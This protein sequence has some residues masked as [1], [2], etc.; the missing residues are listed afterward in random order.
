MSAA[1]FSLNQPAAF[2]TMFHGAPSTAKAPVP[3]KPST[4]LSAVPNIAGSAFLPPTA[5]GMK[6]RGFFQPYRPTTNVTGAAQSAAK[7]RLKALMDSDDDD[8]ELSILGAFNGS[9]GTDSS[10]PPTAGAARPVSVPT[11][12]HPAVAFHR[13]RQKAMSVA[14]DEL[15]GRE[16]ANASPYRDLR[17]VL[18]GS[19]LRPKTSTPMDT[20]SVVGKAAEEDSAS[21]MSRSGSAMEMGNQTSSAINSNVE[22]GICLTDQFFESVQNVGGDKYKII[23]L[24]EGPIGTIGVYS[25]FAVVVKGKTQNNQAW[26]GVAHMS[27][28]SPENVLKL[29][30]ESMINE[31]KCLGETIKFYVIGGYHFKTSRKGTFETARE[32]RALKEKY[33]IVADMLNVNKSSG[34]SIDVVVDRS[35]NVMFSRKHIFDLIGKDVGKRLP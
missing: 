12:V 33:P 21:Q 17:Y 1:P 16:S 25:C 2:P 29:L 34:R 28:Q 26:V 8:D 5:N 20:Q 35:G 22:P 31:K 10:I 7:S 15:K 19:S 27:T 3:V 30:M 6:P 18:S 11:K 23:P 32:F 24:E 4:H 13:A 9:A 14:A